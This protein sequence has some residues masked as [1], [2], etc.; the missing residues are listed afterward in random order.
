ML[1]EDLIEGPIIRVKNK[2]E[3]ESPHS[4]VCDLFIGCVLLIIDR[5]LFVVNYLLLAIDRLLL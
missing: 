4:E 2:E 3:Q 1:K 5:L